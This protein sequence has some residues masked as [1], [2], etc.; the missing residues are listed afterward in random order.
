MS[1][2][3]VRQSLDARVEVLFL[4]GQPG[5]GKTA[6]AKEISELLWK[7]CEPHAVIDLDELCRGVFPTE[8]EGFYRSL[9][10]L[11]LSA[12]W[13]NYH[14]TGIRRLV[15]A[16]IIESL[17]DLEQFSRT[18]PNSHVTVCQIHASEPMIQQRITEREPGSARTFLLE[19][20][21]GIAAK[22]SGLEL[23]GFSVENHQR[24]ITEVADEVLRLADWP[25]PKA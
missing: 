6:I 17:D 20:T 18:I 24:S 8:V 19:I 14:A 13:A 9:A 22:I 1:E 7:I 23:P 15:L 4:T 10:I 3:A 12:V 25:R 16:R 2:D 11:N 21:G 5:A